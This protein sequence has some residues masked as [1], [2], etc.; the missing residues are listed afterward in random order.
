MLL[1]GVVVLDCSMLVLDV[2]GGRNKTRNE[3]A[4]GED[5]MQVSLCFCALCCCW[6][7][8]SACG[9]RGY[10]YQPTCS[11]VGGILLH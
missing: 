4:R 2:G 1:L 9:R 11:V 8:I 3:Q 6:R 7:S 5:H 10:K